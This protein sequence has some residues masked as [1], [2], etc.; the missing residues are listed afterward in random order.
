MEEYI[1]LTFS[2]DSPFCSLA[3]Y[4]QDERKKP[5]CYRSKCLIFQYCLPLIFMAE[6]Q[7]ELW[8]RQKVYETRHWWTM[9]RES[10]QES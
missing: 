2:I 10:Q 4:A 5:K 8:Q 1:K 7:E 9:V 6:V 3:E